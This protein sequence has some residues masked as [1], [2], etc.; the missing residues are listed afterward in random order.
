VE[1]PGRDDAGK[2]ARVA[3]ICPTRL[4][5]LSGKKKINRAVEFDSCHRREVDVRIEAAVAPAGLLWEAGKAANH[6][7]AKGN[8]RVYEASAI[9]RVPAHN[10]P[11]F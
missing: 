10:A 1:T 4:F 11:G 3:A 7:A 8:D 6:S 2:P 5:D 9:E